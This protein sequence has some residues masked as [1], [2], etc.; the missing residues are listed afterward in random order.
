VSHGHFATAID[1][2]YCPL[3][4]DKYSR[5]RHTIGRHWNKIYRY[6]IHSCE[7]DIYSRYWSTIRK[8]RNNIYLYWIYSCDNDIYSRYWST[9]S[10]QWIQRN[11]WWSQTW[12]ITKLGIPQWSASWVCIN[13]EFQSIWSLQ[14]NILKSN[15]IN[16]SSMNRIRKYLNLFKLK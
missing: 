4:R 12:L 7:N 15:R 16:D 10:K 9:I 2:S 1:R 8:Q 3:D 5:Y 6:W 13:L 11:N 14:N